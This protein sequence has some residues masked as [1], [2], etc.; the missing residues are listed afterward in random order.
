M[1]LYNYERSTT[2][3]NQQSSPPNK[4]IEEINLLG[5]YDTFVKGKKPLMIPETGGSSD[6]QLAV[7]KHDITPHTPQYELENKK[8]WITAINNAQRQFPELKAAVWFEEIKPENVP[9]SRRYMRDFRITKNSA[10]SQMFLE[11]VE[12]SD[13]KIV[14]VD[15]TVKNE[16]YKCSGALNF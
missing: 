5:F 9:G 14:F 11:T 1:S 10:L 2:T 16:V 3:N 8:A 13:R 6:T 7:P 12:E 15:G 4:A